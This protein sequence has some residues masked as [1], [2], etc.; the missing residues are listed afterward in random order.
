MKISF[1]KKTVLK[2]K[3]KICGLTNYEDAACAVNLGADYLGF[4]FAESPRQVAAE[5]VASILHNL[6]ENGLRE[7]VK[8]VGVFVNEK[9]EI[10]ESVLSDTGIDSVQLHGDEKKREV[11]NYPFVWYKALRTSTIKDV[12][13]IFKQEQWSCSRLLIDTKVEGIYGGTGKQVA[14]EVAL[15]AKKRIKEYG[16]EFFLA[17]GINPENVYSIVA[18]IQPD[19][20]DVG[21]G[22]EE[23]KGRKSKV[24]LEKLFTEIRRWEKDCKGKKRQGDKTHDNQ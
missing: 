1:N 7:K 15:Y 23:T 21:S 17:G 24:K 16:K 19:G 11:E 6:T 18:T 3:I 13:D 2:T 4:I 5:T 9:R 22:V 8:T 10:I 14:N 12:D 20:I